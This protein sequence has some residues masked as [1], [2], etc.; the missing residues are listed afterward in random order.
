MEESH[1]QSFKKKVE[2][3][4]QSEDDLEIFL[5]Y[6]YSIMNEL[7]KFLLKIVVIIFK[8]K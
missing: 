4:V 3:K 8:Q 7:V 5:V 1:F 2:T 6:G